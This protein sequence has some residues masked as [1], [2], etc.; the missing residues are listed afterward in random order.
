MQKV[1]Y[2]EYSH[3]FPELVDASGDGW[4]IRHV[5]NVIRF[6]T[7]NPDRV[8]VE[9]RRSVDALKRDFRS[10]WADKVLHLQIPLFSPNTKSKW[11]LRFDDVLADAL[12]L[13]PLQNRD[14]PLSAAQRNELSAKTPKGVPLEASILL[15]KYYVVNADFEG[16]ESAFAPG[17]SEFPFTAQTAAPD[18]TQRADRE[19]PF[20]VLPSQNFNAY[21]GTSAFSQKW[22]AALSGTL[23]EKQSAEAVC[24]YRIRPG[25]FS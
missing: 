11:S 19:L 24:K 9:A 4:L 5:E 21:F 7:E 20:V 22:S 16:N 2:A 3:E 12:V 8:R 18:G 13:G 10:F 6:V 25:L 1:N 23:I 15:Y 17:D 14:F